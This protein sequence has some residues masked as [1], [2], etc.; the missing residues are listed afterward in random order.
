VLP[1]TEEYHGGKLA[2]HVQGRGVLTPLFLV[3]VAVGSTDILLALDSIPAV[4]GVTEEPYIV[5]V[6]NA[7]A[8]LG[9]RALF[10]LVSGLLDRL[11]YLS[12]SLVAHPRLHR[13]QARPPL[14]PRAGRLRARD[15]EPALR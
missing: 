15:L 2:T 10:F 1:L 7:F 9:L 6:A 13:C 5:F 12:T 4:F 14:R 8:L 3:L 11:V